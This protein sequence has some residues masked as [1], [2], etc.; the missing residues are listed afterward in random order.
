MKE[1]TIGQED[2]SQRLDKYLRR[3]LPQAA[4]GFLY[5]LLRKKSITLNGR[6]TEGSVRLQPGDV[7]RLYVSDETFGRFAGHEDADTAYEA[8]RRLT[9][10]LAVVYEDDAI[11]AV[12]KPAGLLS[13]KAR[14]SDISL[15]ELVIAYLIKSGSLTKAQYAAFHPS[16]MNRLDYGTSGIVLAAKTLAGARYLAEGIASRSIEKE[17]LC[18]VDGAF[19][20]EGRMVSYSKKDTSANTV[21]LYDEPVPEAVRIETEYAVLRRE[22]GC[23]LVRARLI[24]GKS[25]QI[26]AQLAA[27]GHPILLDKKYGDPEVNRRCPVSYPGQLLHAYRVRFADGRS[28]TAEPPEIFHEVLEKMGCHAKIIGELAPFE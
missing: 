1:F 18:L 10:Q 5:K 6:R 15:N 4:G 13:Q 17:Y 23:T 11:L 22:N 24:T 7:V 28:I 2:A 12:N 26:R 16:V 20:A 14:P 8:Y 25:H 19:M 9:P 3:L 21:T 27:N